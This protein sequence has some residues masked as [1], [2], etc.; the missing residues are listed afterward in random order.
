MNAPDDMRCLAF[1]GLKCAWTIAE[2]RLKVALETS[3]RPWKR[4]VETVSNFRSSGVTS[5]ALNKRYTLAGSLKD[6]YL[7]PS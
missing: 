6:V 4:F 7:H 3:N 1:A 2:N 5:L